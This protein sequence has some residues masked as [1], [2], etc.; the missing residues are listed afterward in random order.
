MRPKAVR[1]LKQGAVGLAVVSLARW[2]WRRRTQQKAVEAKR[3][4]ESEM[5]Q[6]PQE[7]RKAGD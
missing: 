1:L 4:V 6:L 7:P 2:I 5:A 3:S